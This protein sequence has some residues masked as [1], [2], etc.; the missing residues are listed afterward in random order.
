MRQKF[1]D[2]N[3]VEF[4][5]ERFEQIE[6]EIKAQFDNSFVSFDNKAEKLM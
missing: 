5:S 3:N 2:W 4:K 1:L 6:G